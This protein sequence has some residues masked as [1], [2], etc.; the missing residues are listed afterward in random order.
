[1][2]KV[3]LHTLMLT[4]VQLRQPLSCRYQLDKRLAYERGRAMGFESRDKGVTV[5]LGP[6]AGALGRV[7]TSRSV[8]WPTTEAD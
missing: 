3:V 2:S 4:D 7:S 1:M 6:V 5:Q 8:S